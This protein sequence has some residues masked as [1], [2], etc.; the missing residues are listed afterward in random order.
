M[1]VPP[2]CYRP[3]L[4]G[5]LIV[6]AGGGAGPPP[7]APP[8]RSP[9]VSFFVTS[10]AAMQRLSGSQ[11]GFGG[12][13]RFGQPDGL[14]GADEI[15]RRIAETSMPGAGAK[16]W[17]AFLSV[18]KG[19]D[20]KPV[21]A[22]DRV[23]EGPWYDRLGRLVALN[24]ADLIE[25]RP[26][27]ADMLI[28]H[29]LPN[30]DGV[31]NHAPDGTL[32]DNHDILTGT[33]SSGRLYSED[34][35]VTCHDWTSAVGGDGRPRVGH[36]WTRAGGVNGEGPGGIG[37]RFPD[38]GGRRPMGPPPFDGAPPFIIEGPD[39]GEPIGGGRTG[40]GDG[41]RIVRGCDPRDGG[42]APPDG[43]GVIEGACGVP[44]DGE[45]WISTLDE[46]GCAPGVSLIEMGPPDPRNPTVGSGGGY[47]AIY[48]LAL[49]P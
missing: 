39:G 38:D 12:D 46:A 14:S 32:V 3:V 24:R 35:G 6:A 40:D 45:S 19:P 22:I 33:G 41:G 23:G 2:T 42:P 15:C 31:P 8:A 28:A 7:T 16:G 48:C 11:S 17:R 34:W 49:V 4:A 43:P 10:L 29:D 21:H 18:T 47:G 26:K 30:E 9:P 5:L 36:S 37:P 44:G 27:G 20:G 1:T 25:T 13:L